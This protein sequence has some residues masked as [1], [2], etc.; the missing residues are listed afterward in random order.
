MSY[1]QHFCGFR[2]PICAKPR[3]LGLTAAIPRCNGFLSEAGGIRPRQRV[4]S[5]LALSLSERE[6]I[7]RGVVAG[8]SMRS[9]AASMGRAASTV[10]REIG[11][12]GGCQRYRASHAD[13]AAWDQARRPKSCKLVRNRALARLV[14]QKLKMQWSPEQIAGWL[15]CTYPEDEN[16]QVSQETIYRSLFI[17]ARGALKK[18]LL[19]HL[20]RTRVMRRSRHHTQ[21]TDDHGRISNTISISERPP[22]VA[23]RAVPGHWEGDLM[24]GSNNSQIATF[25]GAA[26]PVRDDGQGER[27]G[28]RDRDQRPC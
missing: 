23:D 19:Q 2:Q 24:F 13:Q 15:K 20:R 12:N 7:S 27:Q 9:I 21:K 5:R 4:R 14:A 16:Y 6:V 18:E 26:N 11:R 8:R 25:G 22:S 10:S 17:Q 28:Y 3:K 1:P